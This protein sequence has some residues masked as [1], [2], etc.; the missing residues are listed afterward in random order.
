MLNFYKNILYENNVKNNKINIKLGV[1]SMNYNFI[2]RLYKL[3]F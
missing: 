1:F 2:I 3:M